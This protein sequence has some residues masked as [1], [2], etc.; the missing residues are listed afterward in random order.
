MAGN[1]GHHWEVLTL[2][3]VVILPSIGREETHFTV[4]FDIALQTK[5]A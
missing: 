5:M 2:M 3:I 4:V 1:L